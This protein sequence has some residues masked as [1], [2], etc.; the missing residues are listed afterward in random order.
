MQWCPLQDLLLWEAAGWAE[1]A[2]I[3]GPSTPSIIPTTPTS[4]RCPGAEASDLSSLL[5]PFHGH[6]YMQAKEQ[7]SRNEF[8]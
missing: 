7:G 4:G 8:N 2:T 5:G 1:A 6:V 3:Y